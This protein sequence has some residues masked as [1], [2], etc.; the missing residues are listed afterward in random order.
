MASGSRFSEVFEDELDCLLEKAIPEKTKAATK[1]GVKIFKEWFASQDK[2][3]TPIE[4]QSK[5]ELNEY[6]QLF[7]ACV[8]QKNETC[9]KVSSLKAIR[10]AL[11]RYLRQQPNNK[12]WSIVGNPEVSLANKTLNAICV[13]MMKEGKISS[14]T[15]KNPI[16]KEQ[17]QQLFKTGKLGKAKTTNLSQILR[18]AWFY[19]TL[20]F[21][22]RGRENQRKLLKQMLVLWETPGKGKYYELQKDLPGTMLAK[23]NHQ[24]GPDD[25]A[26]ESD[27]KMFETPDSLRC[28]VKTLENYLKHLNPNVESLFQRRRSESVKFNPDIEEV[29]FCQAP[30]G[31]AMLVNMMKVMCKNAGIEQYL[32]NHCV[33]ATS[34]TVL[35]DSNVEARHIKSVS[36]HKSDQ[37]IQSYSVRP[38]FRQKENMSN[39]LSHFINEDSKDEAST[40]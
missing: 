21:G 33:R 25:S 15:H 11:N 16:T 8:W 35:S 10:A 37:S 20:Y 17:L 19:V 9:F 1:Y 7:Y 22:K 31:E 18:T 34:V 24:G 27:G 3:S 39:I 30:V 4:E 32:T 2:L 38:S 5:A 28:P 12:P 13:N 23:K 36:G 6:L 29:W 40:L 14:V 26:D